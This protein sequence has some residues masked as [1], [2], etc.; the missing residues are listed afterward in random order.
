MSQLVSFAEN[1]P[2]VGLGFRI[3]PFATQILG[4]VRKAM[5]LAFRSTR[6][7]CRPGSER[8]TGI[9]RASGYDLLVMQAREIRGQ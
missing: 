4:R 1:L 8:E 3:R 5:L 6:F 9:P 7:G 2:F